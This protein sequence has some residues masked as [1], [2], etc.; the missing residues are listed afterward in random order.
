MQKIKLMTMVCGAA[1]L[2]TVFAATEKVALKG[3]WKFVKADD[4][5][6]GA[7]YDFKTMGAVLDRADRGDLSGA[8]ANDWSKP[9]F[10]D[11]AWKTVQVPHDW[12]IESTYDPNR[13][14]GDA[15]LDV[16]GVGWYRKEFQVS[17]RTLK[18]DGKDV[19][20]PEIGK[21]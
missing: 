11:S 2:S 4:P 17:D 15:F 21:V 18:V 1:L 6:I 7:S 8:P 9:G 13:R 10:D 20:I 14:Y 19:K 5:K 3:G 16:I 12:G